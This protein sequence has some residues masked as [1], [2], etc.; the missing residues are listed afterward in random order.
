MCSDVY[1]FFLIKHD[2][3]SQWQAMIQYSFLLNVFFSL[4]FLLVKLENGGISSFHTSFS[5]SYF[6]TDDN[7]EEED[8]DMKEDSGINVFI[9]RG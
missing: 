1:T 9:L 7:N 5:F 8:V 6:L 2:N 3:I 4:T